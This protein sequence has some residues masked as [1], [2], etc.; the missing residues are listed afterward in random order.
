MFFSIC[1][2]KYHMHLCFYV[3]GNAPFL[4]PIPLPNPSAR[5]PVHWIVWIDQILVAGG[6]SGSATMV[7]V[8]VAVCCVQ[9]MV[10]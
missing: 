4:Q 3:F 8:F 9:W 5:S 1:N 7:A 2:V 10:L 6:T